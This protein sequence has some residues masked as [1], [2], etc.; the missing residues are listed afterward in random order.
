MVNLLYLVLVLFSCKNA[1]TQD[2]AEPQLINAYWNRWAGGQMGVRGIHFEFVL[3]S[4]YADQMEPISLT[5]ND[6]PLSFEKATIEGDTIVLRSNYTAPRE[7]KIEGQSMNNSKKSIHTPKFGE[8]LFKLN[9]KVVT[10][11]IDSF[12][13]RPPKA[14]K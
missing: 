6:E 5:I 14:Y 3:V 12:K 13:E 1:P 10:F 2:V 4:E 8:L 11:R 9:D 7:M